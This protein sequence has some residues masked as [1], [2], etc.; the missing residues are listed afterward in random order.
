MLE[1]REP[2]V[3]AAPPRLAPP[4]DAAA[5]DSLSAEA[6]APPAPP[7]PP[8]LEV[9]VETVA[10]IE[11]Q[12]VEVGASAQEAV[13]AST[14]PE[15][16]VA[17]VKPPSEAATAASP[18]PRFPWPPPQPS[19]FTEVP[20][21]KAFGTL[22]DAARTLIGA[23][24][25]V[26]YHDRSFWLAPG[27]FVLATRLERISAE[28]APVDEA[29][30]WPRADLRD[31]FSLGAYLSSLFFTEP[32]YFR[33]IVFVVSDRLET[34]SPTE[35]AVAT[36]QAWTNRGMVRLPKFLS[37][38]RFGP[39]HEITALIYEFERLPNAEATVLAP[40]RITGRAHLERALLLAALET[41]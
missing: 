35:P 7:P 33:V 25:E 10:Q 4:P 29:R 30:R 40:G 1:N 23:L 36:A 27:G 20:K 8:E 12:E 14:A 41:R 24:D 21:F 34:T 19:S 9:G 13:A 5:E 18:P 31:D 11:S 6:E 2:S 3:A 37:E 16:T 22:G 38:R 17:A 32:G 39:D 15:R 28:G 26:G